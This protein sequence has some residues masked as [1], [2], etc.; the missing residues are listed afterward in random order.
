MNDEQRKTLA[1]KQLLPITD[2]WALVAMADRVN[3][4][5]YVK[6]PEFNP[7]TGNVTFRPNRDIIRDQ[8]T[9]GLVNISEVDREF[10]ARMQNHFQGLAFDAIGGELKEFDQKVMNLIVK[11]EVDANL[12]MAYLACMA[13]RYRREVAKE[14]KHEITARL[15]GTSTHQGNIGDL[16]KIDVTVLNKF[17][18]KV[19]EGSV[20]RATDGTN[21]Y[22]WS[23]NK[24]VDMWP[25]TPEPF[26]IVGN[27]KAHG[28][29]R[30][31]TQETRLTR[32]KIVL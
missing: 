18:G 8:I 12:G 31:G 6:F 29:D 16:I 9:L 19:F 10:G 32:V 24:G 28:I 20:V 15:T 1:K 22:F 25:D 27:I 13:A 26:P 4:G 7:D 5:K 23:S 14:F 3:E 2:A 21:L 30:D 11:D 17:A